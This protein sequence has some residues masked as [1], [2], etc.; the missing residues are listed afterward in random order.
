MH[1][2][3]THLYKINIDSRIVYILIYYPHI[4]NIY[5]YKG[6]QQKALPSITP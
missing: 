5:I 2:C 1:R 4:K 6:H 3:D